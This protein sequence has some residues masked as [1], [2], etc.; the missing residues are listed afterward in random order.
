MA[1]WAGRGRPDRQEHEIVL[2]G[3]QEVSALSQFDRVVL[4]AEGGNP[5][6]DA[7]VRVE[8]AE[9]I[10]HLLVRR[11][12]SQAVALAQQLAKNLLG[13]VRSGHARQVVA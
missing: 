1:C 3:E 8:V 12:Q 9:A 4:D 2:F 13:Q 11:N 10:H 6:P 5:G 7:Q